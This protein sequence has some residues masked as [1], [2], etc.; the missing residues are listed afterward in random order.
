MTTTQLD[1]DT[2]KNIDAFVH[3]F[4]QKLLD[5]EVMS[6]LFLKH[7]AIDVTEHL[8][9]ISLYWQKMLWGDTQ[10]NNHMM[11]MHRKIDA[12]HTFNEQHYQR[13]LDYF[14]QTASESY[15]GFYTNKALRIAEKVVANMMKHI[16]SLPC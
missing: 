1:L 10:Y 11:S 14:K 6:P 15:D 2:V 8:P 16:S 4:Y 12:K 3:S 9:T 5:D 7:A 13:W